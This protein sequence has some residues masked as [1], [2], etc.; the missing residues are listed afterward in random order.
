MK[1]SAVCQVVDVSMEIHVKLEMAKLNIKKVACIG[2]G[3]IGH[4][5][6][7]F[8]A[9]K[10]FRVVLQDIDEATLDYALKRIRKNLDFLAEKGFLKGE[11]A[12]EILQ[13]IKVTTDLD[14][15]AEKADYIQELS[16]IH[17]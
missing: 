17:I 4:S 5:W 10:G 2:A 1:I 8:F 3:L 11:K 15:A 13:R 9:W 14:E 12:E 6:A 7:A 16:L